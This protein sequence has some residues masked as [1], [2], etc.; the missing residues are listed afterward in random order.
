MSLNAS[1][2]SKVKVVGRFRFSVLPFSML[3]GSFC[4]FASWQI[5]TVVDFLRFYEPYMDNVSKGMLQFAPETLNRVEKSM[6]DYQDVLS[7]VS[8]GNTFVC[9]CVSFSLS[10]PSCFLS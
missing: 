6:E 7:A 1:H 5:S 10:S 4:V 3:L 9:F 8:E 2:I